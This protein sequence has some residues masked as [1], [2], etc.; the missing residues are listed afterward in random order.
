MNDSARREQL[1]ALEQ[2]AHQCIPPQRPE[3]P[4][5]VHCEVG[6]WRVLVL[7]GKKAVGEV[8]GV[9]H[10]MILYELGGQGKE[11]YKNREAVKSWW[12]FRVVIRGGW[13]WHMS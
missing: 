5:H 3:P 1:A 11:Q 7:E 4:E 12:G 9:R 6:T 2:A 10:Q 8:H 13:L